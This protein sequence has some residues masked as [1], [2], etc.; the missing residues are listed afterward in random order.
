[1]KKHIYSLVMLSFICAL[2]T[3]GAEGQEMYFHPLFK[4]KF[5]KVKSSKKV[6]SFKVQRLDHRDRARQTVFINWERLHWGT[7]SD[8]IQPNEV[9]R[10]EVGDGE[11][12]QELT[13]ELRKELRS[14]EKQFAL[15]IIW[16]KPRRFQNCPDVTEKFIE[17][18]DKGLSHQ[19]NLKKL[20]LVSWS[21][22]VTSQHSG[23]MKG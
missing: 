19:K 14:F 13:L 3:P 11:D 9:W 7:L 20:S 17:Y 1:M 18:W 15:K 10:E 2:P 4:K 8:L 23:N 22:A 6:N 12:L 21:T 5:L 16:R